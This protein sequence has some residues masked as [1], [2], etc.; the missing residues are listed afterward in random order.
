MALQDKIGRQDI[1]DKICGLVDSL[2]KDQ[3]FCLSINGAW[4]SGKS[5]VLQM[6]DSRNNECRWNYC[7]YN[8]FDN[9]GVVQIAVASSGEWSTR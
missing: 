3:N 9:R 8:Y 5:F 6:I 4:G 1:V 2:Q 7:N